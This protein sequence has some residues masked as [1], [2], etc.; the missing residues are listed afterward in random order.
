MDFSVCF[1]L[2]TDDISVH[3][4]EIIFCNDEI[5]RVFEKKD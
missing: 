5:N 4:H 3:N 2:K 1:G